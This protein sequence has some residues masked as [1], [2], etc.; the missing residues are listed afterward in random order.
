[1]LEEKSL[2]KEDSCKC[3]TMVKWH[4]GFK[5]GMELF[6]DDPRQWRPIKVTIPKHVKK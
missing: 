1:M 3:K 2:I 5:Q 6:E 4:S